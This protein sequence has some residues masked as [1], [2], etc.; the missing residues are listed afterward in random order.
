MKTYNLKKLSNFKKLF[1]EGMWSNS[2]LFLSFSESE[3]EKIRK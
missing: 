3:L 1:V 2:Q